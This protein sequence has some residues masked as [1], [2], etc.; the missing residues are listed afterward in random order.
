MVVP[1]RVSALPQRPCVMDLIPGKSVGPFLLG[2]TLHDV[3]SLI[4]QRGMDYRRV[5]VQFN[6]VRPCRSDICLLATNIGMRLRFCGYSQRLKLIDIFDP[7]K[8]EIVY[9]GRSL[10][11]PSIKPTFSLVSRVLGPTFPGRRHPKKEVY[12]LQYP[13]ICAVFPISPYINSQETGGSSV[14]ERGASGAG[15]ARRKAVR[16]MNGGNWEGRSEGGSGDSDP[17]AKRFFVHAGKSC[18]ER[19]TLPVSGVGDMYFEPIVVRIKTGI[20]F[21]KRKRSLVF[22]RHTLQH[23]LS[24]LG[25]PEQVYVKDIDTMRIHRTT[26]SSISE[27]VKRDQGDYF[28]NYFRLG[29][30]IVMCGVRHSIKKMVLHTNMPASR[31]FNQYNRCN[32]QIMVNSATSSQPLPSSPPNPTP[33]A[34]DQHSHLNTSN[35]PTNK[36]S[37]QRTKQDQPDAKN[38]AGN[39][40]TNSNTNLPAAGFG[41]GTRV[42]GSGGSG[43]GSGTCCPDRSS[44]AKWISFNTSWETVKQ[45]LGDAGRPMVYGG[46]PGLFDYPNPNGIASETTENSNHSRIFTEHKKPK[47]KD[48]KTIPTLDKSPSGPMI[49]GGASEL[50]RLNPFKSTY[51]YAYDGI[52]FEVLPNKSIA[53]VIL[54]AP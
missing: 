39:S 1:Q 16:G 24:T 53:S 25:T 15:E 22:G 51:F 12:M 43:A 3:I 34:S 9:E 11:G 2:S 5:C 27:C 19:L 18:M 37:K 52:I 47:P 33:A 13:G 38:L 31:N 54:F 48:A 17:K 50:N 46:S 7:E 49:L 42:A 45:I 8:M 26:P 29:M 30:D 10:S 41:A 20:R 6:M 35:F 28:L 4:K 21:H 40:N 14:F 32:Y 36:G 44:G 23:V